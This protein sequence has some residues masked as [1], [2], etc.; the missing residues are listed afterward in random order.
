MLYLF[1]FGLLK[2]ILLEF[3]LGTWFLC[4][5]ILWKSLPSQNLDLWCSTLCWGKLFLLSL[6]IWFIKQNKKLF[7]Q[8]EASCN[9][10]I[11]LLSFFLCYCIRNNVATCYWLK[12]LQSSYSS[13]LQWFTHRHLIQKRALQGYRIHFMRFGMF[14]L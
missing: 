4:I 1:D 11:L 10:I 8:Q 14:L 7:W 12:L 6:M 2:Y 13:T 9:L 5:R 3:Q